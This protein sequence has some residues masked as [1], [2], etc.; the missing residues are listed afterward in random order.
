MET[1]SSNSCSAAVAVILVNWNGWSDTLECVSSLLGQRY[2]NFH[3]FVID[4]ASNDHSVE[5]ICAWCAS[6]RRDAS[7]REQEGVAQRTSELTAPVPVRLADRADGELGAPPPECRLSLVRAG[8]NLGF[9]GGCNVGVRAAGVSNFDY[10]WFLNPDTVVQRDALAAL[11]R[12]AQSDPIIGMVGSTIRYYDRP[13]VIQALGGARVETATVRSRHLGEGLRIG[14][15]PIDAR[16]IERELFYIMGASMLV[17]RAFVREVGLMRE[18]YFLFYE[19]IDWAMRNRGRFTLGYASDSHIFHK[20]GTASAKASVFATNLY[21]R[22]R[23]RFVTR[24]FPDRLGAVRLTMITD[25]LR[26]VV[27]GRWPHVRVVA[28]VLRDSASIAAQVRSEA[29]AG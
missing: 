3:I 9:A 1:D 2:S 29:G 19:E 6:P 20:A 14:S 17:S 24:F 16:K 22:N 21:Y 5:E 25:L 23:I 8:G 15:Q 10:F 13:E 28:G 27:R 7:W 18:D 4:N 12:R 26:H 11:V